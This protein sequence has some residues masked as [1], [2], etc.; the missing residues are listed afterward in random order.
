[1]L[2][3]PFADNIG[4]DEVFYALVAQRWLA[5]LL[6]YVSS[7]DVKPPGLFALFAA[8]QAVFGTSMAVVKGLETGCVAVTAF[9]LWLVGTR[10]LSRRIGWL[11]GALY[12]VY[13]LALSGV[14]APTE[15]VKAPF[16]TFAV[17]AVLEAARA[18]KWRIL[19]LAI[20]GLLM[21]SAGMVKQ[22]A[23]FPALVLLAVVLRWGG[24]AGS[25]VAFGAG[26]AV[27][28]TCF[29]L[30]FLVAGQWPALLAGAV[31][32]AAGRLSGDNI[33]FGAGLLRFLPSTKPLMVLL[34]TALLI[35]TRVRTWWGS[36]M[37]PGIVVAL[38]WLAGEAA[39]IIATRSMY[40]HYFLALAPPLVLLAAV[41][42]FYL[43]Q[44]RRWI[45]PT[46][47]LAFAWPAGPRWQPLGGGIDAGAAGA[48]ARALTAAGVPPDAPVLVA[49]RSLLVTLLSRRP[50]A[51]RYFHP[52]HLLCDFPAPDADPLAVALEAHPG[53][54]VV[55][56]E[57][58]G[59]VCERADRL[60]ELKGALAQSYCVAAHIVGGSDSY[61]LFVPKAAAWAKCLQVR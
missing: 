38:A 21:G 43:L 6:P 4:E 49:N 31:T 14:N 57:S 44:A 32:G 7:F 16:E 33:S 42:V 51:S 25:L 28:P 11:A 53:G 1:M 59:M 52:Q 36:P 29:A 58:R 18:G 20:S 10:H 54:I 8:V 35:V 41:F 48:V 22:T 47:L 60:G 55:A 37:A 61:D 46:I 19:L 5:G 30:I 39:G 2:R 12:P 24:R 45:V 15:L 17:L 56:D 23:A 3:L 9:G 34:V 26:L 27:A 40:D 13:S 50:P